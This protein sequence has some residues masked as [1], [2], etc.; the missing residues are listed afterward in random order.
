MRRLYLINDVTQQ[1]RKPHPAAA[2]FSSDWFQ[3]ARELAELDGDLWYILSAEYGL[4]E[5]DQEIAPYDTQIT[6]FDE[7]DLE[8]W[9]R[10]FFYELVKRLEPGDEIVLL[11]AKEYR[12]QIADVLKGSDYPTHIPLTGMGYGEQQKWLKDKISEAKRERGMGRLGKSKSKKKCPKIKETGKMWDSAG[13]AYQ[14]VKEAGRGQYAIA[15]VVRKGKND[16]VVKRLHE[17]REYER[18]SSR[19]FNID[20][21]T[22]LESLAHEAQNYE[23][24][25]NETDI[26][27]VP[28]LIEVGKDYFVMEYIDG[29]PFDVWMRKNPDAGVAEEYE[30]LFQIVD[31]AARLNEEGFVS[32]DMHFGNLLVVG[33]KEIYYID[34]G[35]SQ[36]VLSPKEF[37]KCVRKDALSVAGALEDFVNRRAED[38]RADV[39]LALLRVSEALRGEG[40][41]IANRP[42]KYRADYVAVWEVVD[43]LEELKPLIK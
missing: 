12:D 2:L 10:Q 33:G 13:S 22:A 7:Y 32:C 16:Y 31:K 14:R 39:A 8:Q 35:T 15:D 4:L 17:Q 40:I 24:L 25:Q 34:F 3:K 23:Y 36:S 30:L 5:P 1:R 28:C 41:Q 29:E 18:G 19:F 26:D 11:A 27:F 21:D 37:I 42:Q 38:L 43:A 6:D 9:R 20:Y